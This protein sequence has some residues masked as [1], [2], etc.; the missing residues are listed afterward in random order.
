M[1]GF[2]IT[3]EDRYISTVEEILN[4]EGFYIESVSFY[5]KA[6]FCVSNNKK[7]GNSILNNF[8]QIYIQD[9]ASMLPP[10]ILNPSKGSTVLDLCASPGG[11]SAILSEL[12]GEN[13]IVVANEPNKKR[14]LTLKKN[15]E[16]LNL[17]NVCFTC[18]PGE[19]F[20]EYIKFPY[21]L[22]DVPCSGW[23]TQD[24]NP[25]VKRLWYGKKI[26]PLIKLQRE[27][28]TKAFRLLKP[29]G[30]LVY[31]TCTTNRAENEDQIKWAVNELGFKIKAIDKIDDFEYFAEKSA[32][33]LAIKGH[34]FY[35]QSF[36]VACL[37]KENSN[38]ES[39]GDKLKQDNNL[40]LLDKEKIEN[41]LKQ[42]GLSLFRFP[43][44]IFYL[45]ENKVFFKKQLFCK[46]IYIEGSFVGKLK[47]G[48][49]IPNNRLWKVFA[50]E[51]KNKLVFNE[52]DEIK[53]LISG[54]S[55][56]ISTNFKYLQLYY[57]D[58]P[59]TLLTV[60]GKRGLISR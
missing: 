10:L 14:Y 21:I 26:D 2:R 20:P 43:G 38:N 19:K 30:K 40:K 23:G 59:L 46:E 31:S 18:Y 53:G 44:G 6:R 3:V 51:A 9:L 22:L 50:N 55:V 58:L 15:I 54:K 49:F 33:T 48:L 52:I 45:K 24:K 35:S 16:R 57:K 60:K 7:L 13:G 4:K 11:K 56:T 47:K 39:H 42:A 5:P 28:L 41:M 17:F 27:L 29:G 1:S 25:K 32:G 12:V 36:F 34:K 8:G 37:Y